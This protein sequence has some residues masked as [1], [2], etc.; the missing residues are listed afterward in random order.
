MPIAEHP[1]HRSGRAA[2]PHPA[3]TSGRERPPRRL[4]PRFPTGRVWRWVGVI[5]L[6]CSLTV[7]AP[8]ET[9][10]QDA[11]ITFSFLRPSGRAPQ[12]PLFSFEMLD[13][14]SHG[15]LTLPAFKVVST[16]SRAKV[17]NYTMALPVLSLA[18]LSV[19]PQYGEQKF[20]LLASSLSGLK[21]KSQKVRGLSLSTKHGSS[22]FS[23]MLGQ[24][25]GKKTPFV[26][27]PSVLAFTGTL[28][29]SSWLTFEPRAVTRLGSQSRPGSADTSMGAGVSAAL[30]SH[31]KLI[32]DIAG[33]RT[34]RG[35]WAPSVVVGSVGK[36]SRGSVEASLRRADSAY[37]PMGRVRSVEQNQELIKGQ[38]TVVRGVTV[39]GQLT[40]SRPRGKGQDDAGRVTQAMTFKIDQVGT[41]KLTRKQVTHRSRLTDELKVEWRQ[42]GFGQSVIR[43]T[44]ER[45]RKALSDREGRLVRQLQVEL[46]GRPGAR[47]SLT[48]RTSVLLSELAPDRS[49]VRSRVKGRVAVGGRLELTGEAEYDL[50]GNRAAAASIGKVR[51]GGDLALSDRTTL[52]LVYSRDPRTP[53]SG[54]QQLEGRISRVVSF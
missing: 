54:F 51:V 36:W 37:T 24:L 19:T 18:G 23:L 45:E 13:T 33:A 30:S 25:S 52:H 39:T 14:V 49:R 10:A 21:V 29:P 53:A 4:A 8:Q 17:T 47:V 48:G 34:P 42:E 9:F 5:T 40:T 22:A 7:L 46:E 6:V 41:L 11:R 31:V 50:F 35:R 32:G 43:L 15:G 26:G 28:Q 2:L 1:L 16:D 20:G 3:P 44:E 12:A 38:L 27:M